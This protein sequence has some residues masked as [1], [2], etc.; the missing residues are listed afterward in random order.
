M[1]IFRLKSFPASTTRRQES[2]ARRTAESR[3]TT[4]RIRSAWSGR[5]RA[6]RPAFITCWSRDGNDLRRSWDGRMQA[7]SSAP[8]IAEN[9][10]FELR[11]LLLEPKLGS[12]LAD[13]KKADAGL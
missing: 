10:L 13:A 2:S 1:R 8:T 3:R 11:R 4:I 6:A 12:A 7:S 5:R 9:S